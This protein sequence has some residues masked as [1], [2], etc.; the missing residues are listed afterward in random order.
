MW[1]TAATNSLTD[2]PMPNSFRYC[3]LGCGDGTTLHYLASMYPQA[4]FVGVDFNAEHIAAANKRANEAQLNNI[5]FRQLDF[6]DLKDLESEP[7]DF[8]VCYGAFSWINISLQEQILDFVGTR[9]Q[10]GGL[11]LVHYAA[12]PGKVQIDPL[13]HLMRTVAATVP[14]DSIDQVRE[15]IKVISHLQEQKSIFFQQ[16]PIAHGRASALSKQDLNHIAHESLT[17]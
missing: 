16:N 5:E 11:F 13:W 14:G 9:L 2:R 10:P 17:E 12:K 6:A 1:F 15:G 3:D 4:Q 8:I 7:F